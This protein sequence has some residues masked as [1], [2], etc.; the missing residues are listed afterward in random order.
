M[1][2]MSVCREYYQMSKL[3]FS[4]SCLAALVAASVVSVT[5]AQQTQKRQESKPEQ[6]NQDRVQQTPGEQDNVSRMLAACVAINNQHELAGLQFSLEHI[7]NPEVKQFAE[8]LIK[9]HTQC[10]EKLARYAPA[11]ANKKFSVSP[12]SRTTSTNDN[13]IQQTSAEDNPKPQRETAQAS[14]PKQNEVTNAA[15]R[16][17]QT[18][19]AG[20]TELEGRLVSIERE[21]AEECLSL[22]IKELTQAKEEG[23]FDKAF[24][25]CQIAAHLGMVAKLTVYADEADG[26][27][28]Q[29]F[30]EGQTATE[31]HLAQA[32]T[33][34]NEIKDVK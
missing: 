10:A 33:L 18:R 1:E 23:D 15:A 7:Q 17:T 20:G 28:K 6:A 9:E 11:A 5:L 25:G 27:L 26:E 34:M 22:K 13:R 4:K 2:Q 16:E 3:I 21:A 24:L 29:V 12:G 32:K 19:T 31:K 8:M 14:D 30:T